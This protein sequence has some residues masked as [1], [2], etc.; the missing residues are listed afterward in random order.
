M[1][2]MRSTFIILAGAILWGT[3]GT[4]QA[5][6]P[7]NSNA[8][9]LGAFRMMIGGSVLLLVAMLLEKKHWQNNLDRIG[10]SSRLKLSLF[11]G[12]CAMA[13]YQPMFFTGVKETGVAFGTVLAIGSAPIFTAIFEIL[14]G[15]KPSIIWATSTCM[16]LI[17][18][19]LLYTGR[20][21]IEVN[22]KGALFSLG[23]GLSYSI[24][25]ESSKWAFDEISRLT[26][27]AIIFTFGGFLLFPIILNVDIAWVFTLN[28]LAVVLHLGIITTAL[29]YS[30][31]AIG[32]KH[33][34]TSTAVTLTLA[35]PLTA[36]ILGVVLFKEALPVLSVVGIIILFAGLFLSA[37]PNRFEKQAALSQRAKETC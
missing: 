6:S 10:K 21:G 12:G 7:E 17:G 23:A 26:A 4:A 8:M 25:V 22:I 28:G 29:G 27:N 35:E 16:A 32:L 13:L 14:K 5:V 9:S 1:K 31:F 18:C 15:R 3:T 19:Y 37:V 30:L 2:K 24:Y 20:G 36:T 34:P 11:C 33:V